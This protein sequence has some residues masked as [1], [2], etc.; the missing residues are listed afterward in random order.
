MG[1]RVRGGPNGKPSPAGE[2][3]RIDRT[4]CVGCEACLPYRPVGAI[5]L[6]KPAGVKGIGRIQLAESAAPGR[7]SAL[8]RARPDCSDA[9]REVR[10]I[11]DGVPMRRDLLVAAE[12]LGLS[13]L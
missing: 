5:H 12:R 13:E 1:V 11:L 8:R 3:M 9:R 10:G 7:P 6:V 4:R 2:P